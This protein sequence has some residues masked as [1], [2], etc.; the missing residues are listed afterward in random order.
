MY[1]LD[2]YETTDGGR[3]SALVSASRQFL[4]K[5]RSDPPFLDRIITTDGM[6]VH[7]NEP[8]DIR[9]SMVWKNRDSPPPKKAKVIIFHGK[10][11]VCRIHG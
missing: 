6:W 10:S 2:E 7:Y 9:M 1:Q 5:S 3:K 8:E 11:D 4:D